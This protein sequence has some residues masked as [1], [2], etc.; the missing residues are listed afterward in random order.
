MPAPVTEDKI[1]LAFA[2]YFRVGGIELE[3]SVAEMSYG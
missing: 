3:K 1:L 2:M